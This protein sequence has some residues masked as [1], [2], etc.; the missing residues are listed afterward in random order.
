LRELQKQKKAGNNFLNIMKVSHWAKL[1]LQ[2]VFTTMAVIAMVFLFLEFL[3]D[4]AS[5]DGEQDATNGFDARIVR[6]KATKNIA[7]SFLQKNVEFW[8]NGF[9][10]DLGES[11]VHRGYTVG[12][13][14]RKDGQISIV[15]L[16][17]TIVISILAGGMLGVA[18][19]YHRDRWLGKVIT[20]LGLMFA[21]TP[22]FLLIPVLIYFFAI[23]WPFFPVA[24]WEGIN[25]LVLPVTALSI[26][27]IFFLA[28]MLAQQIEV[29]MAAEFI[30][31]AKAK[32]L[33]RTH[34]WIYHILPM[35]MTAFIV[36]CGNLFG[37][38]LTG[39]FLVETLFGLPGLGFLF[40]KS[41]AER[42]YPVFLGLILVFTIFLQLGHRLADLILANFGETKFTEQELVS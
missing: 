27:P 8:K 19:G 26:R 34:I 35:S 14:I 40:V 37:Q 13:I 30:V 31:M 39:L 16:C 10:Y 11:R 21:S 9:L 25:S 22:S 12:Q 41:L 7:R 24:L 29:S 32:G 38:L 36:G 15:L 17:M 20:F 33:T 1:I 18:Q 3:P 2:T 5:F 6:E 28:R 23:R 4:Y 42:D